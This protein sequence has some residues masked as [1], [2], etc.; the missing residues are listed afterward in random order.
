MMTSGFFSTMNFPIHRRW[1]LGVPGR[2]WVS[3]M[4]MWTVT[5]HQYI[6]TMDK[7]GAQI[8]RCRQ[9]FSSSNPGSISHSSCRIGRGQYLVAVVGEVPVQFPLD[10]VDRVT[11]TSPA[12]G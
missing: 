9:N 10:P 8:L 12:V 11:Q 2:L 5:P 7:S 6:R 1:S 4:N 3:G